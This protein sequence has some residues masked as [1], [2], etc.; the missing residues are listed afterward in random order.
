M[1]I[2]KCCGLI[3]VFIEKSG[4]PVIS[5]VIHRLPICMTASEFRLE[6][7]P[8]KDKLYR[9]A[10]S[11][12]YDREQAQDIVQEVYAKLWTQRDRLKDVHN[13]EAWCVRCTRN[14][15]IDKQRAQKKT[16]DLA[17]TA[18]PRS[19]ASSDDRLLHK[20]LIAQIRQLM[21]QLPE[22]Q[23]EVFRLRDLMGYSNP[24][25]GEMLELEQP[26]V[27]V[28]LCRARKKIKG[29]L[30]KRID[31]GLETNCT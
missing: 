30:R 13:L 9:F 24:E 14:L 7:L 25:I 5:L 2:R 23:Q 11:K 18:E 3:D 12:I 16:T 15:I 31:Y 29:L 10:I 27:R 1:L 20:D 26:E 21:E 19:H 4:S 8:L 17:D 22:R 6:L 28:H